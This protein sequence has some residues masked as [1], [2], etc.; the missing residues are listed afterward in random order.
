M[1]EPV[2]QQER[3]GKQIVTPAE[4]WKY[5]NPYLRSRISICGANGQCFKQ[6]TSP[7]RCLRCGS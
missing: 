1:D 6:I 2:S 4:V 3:P 5:L 7:R